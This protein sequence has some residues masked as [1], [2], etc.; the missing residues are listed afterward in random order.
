V[1]APFDL[2]HQG[3]RK[4]QGIEGLLEGLGGPLRLTAVACEALLRCAATALSGFG[5]F[6]DISFGCGHRVLRCAKEA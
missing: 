2:G 1:Q 6:F 4:P 5:V 3:F